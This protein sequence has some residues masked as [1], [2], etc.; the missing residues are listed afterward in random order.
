VD[1]VNNLAPFSFF[2]ALSANPPVIGFS[3]MITRGGGR[4]DSRDNIKP[5]ASS[6]LILFLGTLP[7]G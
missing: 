7:N 4:R 2:T 6:W 5:A 1:G 3:P